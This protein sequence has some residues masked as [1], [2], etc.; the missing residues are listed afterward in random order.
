MAK[1]KT[2]KQKLRK[3]RKIVWQII[4]YPPDGHECR[5][6][7]GYPAEFAYDEFAYKRMCD[8]YRVGLRSALDDTR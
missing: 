7:D 8:S 4:N 6:E 3:L 2:A 5:D 1:Q